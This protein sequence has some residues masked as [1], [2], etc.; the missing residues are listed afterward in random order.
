MGDGHRV[1]KGNNINENVLFDEFLNKFVHLWHLCSPLVLNKSGKRSKKGKLNWYRI[2]SENIQMAYRA[3][4]D[5]KV[6]N[7]E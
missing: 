1:S 3:Y 5:C 7:C 6:Y 4:L 2:K